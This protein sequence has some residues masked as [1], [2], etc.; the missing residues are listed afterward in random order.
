VRAD[1]SI[2]AWF[3]HP[4]L[5]DGLLYNTRSARLRRSTLERVYGDVSTYCRDLE[6][7]LSEHDVPS[8]R[9]ALLAGECS[10]GTLVTAYLPW[11]WSE[12]A[13]E[14]ARAHAGEPVRSTF[15][16]Y[17]HDD[18]SE[19]IEVLGTFDPNKLTCS[20][21]NV[22][23]RGQR[24]Q[25][26]LAQVA[27]SGT[28]QIELRPAAIAT[29]LLAPPPSKWAMDWQRVYPRQVDSFAGVDW[30]LPVTRE[31][32]KRLK[33]I[34]ERQVKNVLA[35]LI[36][37]ES[38]SKDWGG[39]INDLYTSRLM[40]D[41]LQASAAF[42]LK[43]PARF[44]PMTIAHLGQNGDQLTRLARSPAYVLVLQHCHE[45]RQEVVSYLQDTASN[46]RHVRRYL[47]LDG[48]DTYRMLA[49]VG[50]L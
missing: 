47:V 27:G 28:N 13:K 45:I 16:A 50:V 25:W 44:S 24:S 31:Q 37:E 34:P 29:L 3:L 14:R 26:I 49:G 17:L 38:V 42:L 9:H 19:P 18:D 32:L 48:Y 21:S 2:N 40:I 30:D 22:E 1:P 6:D 43:G 15:W 46:F 12:V 20:T 7:W 41:G 11:T 8:P 5:L 36:G 39:E 4:G 10:A 23:L 35:R 33:D